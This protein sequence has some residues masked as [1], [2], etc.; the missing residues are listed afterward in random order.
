MIGNGKLNGANSNV[1]GEEQPKM[2]NVMVAAPSYDGTVSAWHVS[3]LIESA[4]IG[5]TKGINILPIYMSYD[6]LI[7]RARNDIFQLAIDS[8]VDDLVF[9]DCD[10]DWD[11]SFLFQLLEHDVPFVGAPVVKKSDVEMYNVKSLKP[12]VSDEKTGLCEVD[13]IGTGFLRVRA[14]ALLQLWNASPEYKEPHKEV[15]SRMVFDVQI[16]DGELWS[17]D[18]VFCQKWKKLGGKVMID[19]AINPGHSGFKRW[20]GNF[21]EWYN[22]LPK[23]T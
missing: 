23:Q 19:P 10:Q 16:V 15:P 14:D 2:R 5:L 7:Q 6:A 8:K 22:N 4:K 12:L 3:S 1:G 18:V 21:T 9:I 20:A 11:P 13:S 17:E